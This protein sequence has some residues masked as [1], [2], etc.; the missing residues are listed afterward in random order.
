[1]C[2][3]LE[4][5]IF[6]KSHVRIPDI[7]FPIVIEIFSSGSVEASKVGHCGQIWFQLGDVREALPFVSC[8]VSSQKQSEIV[9]IF[10]SGEHDIKCFPVEVDQLSVR[11]NQND[12]GKCFA[13]CFVGGH[14]K[15]CFQRESGSD[16][17]SGCFAAMSTRNGNIHSFSGVSLANGNDDLVFHK[18]EFLKSLQLDLIE[19]VGFFDLNVHC[20]W[21]VGKCDDISLFGFLKEFVHCCLV[22]RMEGVGMI[23][24]WQCLDQPKLFVDGFTEKSSTSWNKVFIESWIFQSLRSERC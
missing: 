16:G 21:W 4:F 10:H 6:E 15:G 8:G 17:D 18:A 23:R 14:G 2:S 9:A 13:F 3:I 24:T 22:L 12:S 1:M 11:K 19:E 5:L 7:L 20:G